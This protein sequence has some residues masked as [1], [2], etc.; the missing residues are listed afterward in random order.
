V[1]APQCSPS[2]PMPSS[3]HTTSEDLVSIWLPH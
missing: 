2:P 3:S 1:V